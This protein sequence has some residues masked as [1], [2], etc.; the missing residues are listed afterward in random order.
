[1]PGFFKA[2]FLIALLCGLAVIAAGC[3][4]QSEAEPTV[5]ASPAGGV[6]DMPNP[7]NTPAMPTESAGAPT[8]TLEPTDAPAAPTESAGTPAA[9]PEPTDAPAAPTESAGSPTATPFSS[10][11]E[12]G[13]EPVD[14]GENT[15]YVGPMLLGLLQ[16]YADGAQTPTH[17][18][19]GIGYRTDLNVQPALSDYIESVGGQSIGEYTWRIPTANVLSVIQRADVVAAG[20]PPGEADETTTMYERMDSTMNTMMTAYA[21]GATETAAAQ[22]AFGADN[23]KVVVKIMAP[24]AATMSRIRTWFTSQSLYMPPESAFEAFGVDT[25]YAMVPVSRFAAL[26]EAFPTT[27]LS[28]DTFHRGQGLSMN[29]R[30][31]PEYPAKLEA[32][33]VALYSPDYGGGSDSGDGGSG[34]GGQGPATA[35]P[36]ATTP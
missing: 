29:R 20:F 8:A 1:M 19:I 11:A 18:E 15:E 4:E 33:V 30:G 10:G 36:E 13:S 3:G 17:V 14:L 22:Y 25:R 26:T 9:T 27:Y 5:G 32:G 16:R 35:T 6:T 7:T 34:S 31:W 28:V 24:D 12:T 2:T 21:H 23:G